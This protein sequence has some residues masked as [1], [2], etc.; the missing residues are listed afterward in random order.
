MTLSHVYNVNG[1]VLKHPAWTLSSTLSF[2]PW[3]A[4]LLARRTVTSFLWD[5]K[6][7]I[8]IFKPISS[9]P[10]PLVPLC[11]YPQSQVEIKETLRVE[12]ESHSVVSDSVWLHGL[13]PT[14][15]LCPWNSPGKNTGVGSHSLLQGIF[16]TQGSNPGLLHGRQIL[17]PL[18]HHH[19]KCWAAWSTNWN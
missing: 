16:P 3:S 10:S 12:S 1:T 19:E 15:L 18:S 11:T 5:P 8:I 6:D 4:E 7:L 9:V 13:Q 17:Y 14:R 2:H